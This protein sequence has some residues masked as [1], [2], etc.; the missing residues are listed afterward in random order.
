MG[1]VGP[2]PFDEACASQSEVYANGIEQACCGKFYKSALIGF[3]A[4]VTR[5]KGKAVDTDNGK[6]LD[7]QSPPI[8]TAD[9]SDVAHWLG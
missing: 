2:L 4:E 9:R 5:N 6:A 7:Y 1:K 8:T 3:D